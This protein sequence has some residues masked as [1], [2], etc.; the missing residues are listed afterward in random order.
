MAG[1]RVQSQPMDM[2]SLGVWFW[3]AVILLAFGTEVGSRPKGGNKPSE[4]E[5]RKK[6]NRNRNATDGKSRDSA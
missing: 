2:H 1:K 4:R 6:T 3:V 5:N